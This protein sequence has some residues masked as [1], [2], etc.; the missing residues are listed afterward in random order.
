[1]LWFAEVFKYKLESSRVVYFYGE[2]GTYKTLSA[3]AAAKWLLSTG[4]Y[5]RVYANTPVS[6]ASSPPDGCEGENFDFMADYARDSIFVIDESGLFMKGTHESIK[7]M[8]ALPRHR[9]Q[10]FLLASVIPNKNAQD[11][12]QLFV[13]YTW[14]LSMFGLPVII[15][16]SGAWKQA[17][18][19][20]PRH[21]LVGFKGYFP[22][23]V[24]KFDP[25]SAGPIDQWHDKGAVYDARSNRVPLDIVHLYQINN[26]GFAE[27]KKRLK[28]EEQVLID[29]HIKRFD[30]SGVWTKV[31]NMPRLR[32]KRRLL[33]SLSADFSLGITVRVIFF[34]YILVV[35]GRFMLISNHDTMPHEFTSSQWQNFLMLQDPG[36]PVQ[37]ASPPSQAAPEQAAPLQWRIEDESETTKSH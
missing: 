3:I 32:R 5:A 29:A 20:Q 26:W 23:Y 6:F 8:F 10:V 28:P 19:R 22:L 30:T 37:A 14:K 2:V 17:E 31:E 4:R 33:P 24:S 34:I 1:M 12:C 13:T 7:T 9:N 25:V 36:P 15:F 21:W 16:R 35:M 18:K 27:P 11:Y